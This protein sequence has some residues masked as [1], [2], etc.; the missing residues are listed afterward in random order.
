[1]NKAVK[2]FWVI[3]IV[4]IIGGFLGAL[5]KYFTNDNG[6]MESVIIALCMLIPFYYMKLWFPHKLK[7]N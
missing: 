2:F 4:A 5:A 7:K 6:I 1:M 3:I